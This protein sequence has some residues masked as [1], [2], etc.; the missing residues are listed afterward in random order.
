MA[1]AKHW[2]ALFFDQFRP[3]PRLGNRSVRNQNVCD[4]RINRD[5]LRLSSREVRLLDFLGKIDGHS[6]AFALFIKANTT[7]REAFCHAGNSDR[8]AQNEV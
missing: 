8:A 1:G 5:A 4:E 3:K 7:G 6:H 2:Y